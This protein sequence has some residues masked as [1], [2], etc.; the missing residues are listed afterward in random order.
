MKMFYISTDKPPP[1]HGKTA[2]LC[3]II[4]AIVVEVVRYRIL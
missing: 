1:S 2:I 4:C 3:A